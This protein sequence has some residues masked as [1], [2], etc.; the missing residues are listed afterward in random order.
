[1]ARVLPEYLQAYP[2]V[3]L[4]LVA[5]DREVDLIAEGRMAKVLEHLPSPELGMYLVYP[6]TR[7][8]PF[9]T[10]TFI[11]AVVARVNQNN[12]V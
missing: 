8:L 2:K 10:R 3:D 11:D 7:Q 12:S 6:Q 5:I 9:K 1:M 4:E